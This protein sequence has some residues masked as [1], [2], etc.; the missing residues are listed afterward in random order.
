MFRPIALF[1]CAVACFA[2][3]P[4]DL[5]NRPPEDVDRALRARIT[6]FYQDQVEG[7]FRQAEALVAEDTK[8]YY[9]SAN[10]I[11]YLSFEIREIH[12]S[13]GFTRAKAVILC[14]QY[15][16]MPGFPAK[17]MKVPS[18]S[19]WKLVDGQWYWYV[20][21]DA[22]KQTPFG[23]LNPGPS[24]PG[25]PP[26]APPVL[27]DLQQMQKMF[28]QQ[29]KI[30]KVSVTIKP[31]ESSEVTITNGASGPITVLLDG[32]VP[33][34]EANLDQANIAAAGKSVLTLRARAGAKP[35]V[36]TL[37]VE[38]T[39]QVLPIQVNVP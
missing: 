27:P 34:V 25:A 9:Y 19:T 33:G 24:T 31:G 13:E 14:E 36:L 23:K 21:Q 4:A 3:A 17:P 11:K 2:Q 38:Q 16:V 7:K 26:P 30:D 28:S 10:K 15:I 5:F 39:N 22:L 12:Y 37:R 8:D 18:P 29:V 32:S 20:D 6:E 35:G 1:F